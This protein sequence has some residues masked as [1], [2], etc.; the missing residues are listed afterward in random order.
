MVRLEGLAR[1]DPEGTRHVT[2]R[3][4]SRPR[5]QHP[6]KKAEVRLAPGRNRLLIQAHDDQGRIVAAEQI[7][8][9]VPAPRCRLPTS[10]L[11][12][13]KVEQSTCSP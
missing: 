1:R 12:S 4:C 10:T 8:H 6:W 7:V 13:N 9:Y 11:V 5:A 3:V 2:A